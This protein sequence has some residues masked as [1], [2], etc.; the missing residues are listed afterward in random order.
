MGDEG[1]RR[2]RAA[3]FVAQQASG[4]QNVEKKN[5]VG[6]ADE[7]NPPVVQLILLALKN[8]PIKAK[9]NETF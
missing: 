9:A 1:R 7:G 8:A 5:F 6:F 3:G 2:W 4:V